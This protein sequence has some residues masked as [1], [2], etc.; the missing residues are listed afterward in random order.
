MTRLF[1]DFVPVSGMR[2]L[3]TT[4]KTLNALTCI[5]EVAYALNAGKVVLDDAPTVPLAI[6]EHLRLG[7]RLTDDTLL[8]SDIAS[9]ICGMYATSHTAHQPFYY[10]GELYYTDDLPNVRIYK[11]GQQILGHFD[12]YVQ[13][14]NP[15]W[16]GGAM[17][18]EA[19]KDPDPKRPDLWEVWKWGEWDG[20]LEFVCMGANP[21]YFNGWLYWGVWNGCGFDYER[22]K[23]TQQEGLPADA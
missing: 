21:A 23:V 15:H 7:H 22:A 4:G 18:F 3:V 8:Y 6:G 11:E 2:A 16:G 14:G 17:F 1:E 19:R 9:G 20:E 12:G 10:R 5:E 13:V